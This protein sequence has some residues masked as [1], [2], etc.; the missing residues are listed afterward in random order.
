V[1]L[2]AARDL[3]QL[4]GPPLHGCLLNSLPGPLPHNLFRASRGPWPAP[5]PGFPGL[6]TAPRGRARRGRRALGAESRLRPLA[7]PSDRLGQACGLVLG[8]QRIDHLVERLAREDLIELVQ[9][10]VD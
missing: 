9:G 3:D 8:D 1:D 10:Q 7:P 4:R 2:A 5:S 6:Y